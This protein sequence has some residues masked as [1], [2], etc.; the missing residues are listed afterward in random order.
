MINTNVFNKHAPVTDGSIFEVTGSYPVGFVLMLENQDSTNTI[1]YH[2][3][4]SPDGVTWTPV[5]LPTDNAGN[6]AVDFAMLAGAVHII[7]YVPTNV[8]TRLIAHG[9]ANIAIGF[10]SYRVT[11]TGTAQV[12]ILQT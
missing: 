12:D 4:T 8:R 6:T 10:V 9:D 11:D 3:E 7:K 2:L 5:T 1:V